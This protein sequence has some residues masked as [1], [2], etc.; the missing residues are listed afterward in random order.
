MTGRRLIGVLGLVSVLTVG[1]ACGAVTD[2]A[3]NK[4]A[5]KATEKALEHGSDANVDID[6]KTGK[7]K[8]KAKDGSASWETDGKGNVK[9]TGEDGDDTY[10]VG[11]GAKVPR[12]WPSSIKLPKGL[13]VISASTSKADGGSQF[14]VTGTVKGDGEK[15]FDAMLK[16]LQGA[17]FE[18]DENNRTNMENGFSGSASATDSKHT[19]VILVSESESGTTFTAQVGPADD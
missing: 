2:K 9:I 6:S 8:V 11:K 14:M 15:T 19:A 17:G 4:I 18:L 10:S 3:T 7:V 5:E 12:G 13:V 16:S 1:S